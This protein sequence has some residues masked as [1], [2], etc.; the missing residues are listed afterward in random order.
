VPKLDR[1][2]RSV[3]DARGIG[4]DLAARGI[5]LSLGGQVYDP[6]DPMGKIF[7]NIL[8]TFAEFEVDLLRMRTREGMAVARAKGRLRGRQP[9][10]SA[11]QQAGPGTVIFGGGLFWPSRL[12]VYGTYLHTILGPTLVVG[13][14]WGLLFAPLTVVA[15]DKVPHTASGGAASLRNTAQQAGGSIGLAVLAAVAFTAAASS[16]RA[17]VA[18][19]VTAARAG[20]TGWEARPSHAAATGFSRG[21]DV[22]AGIMLLALIITAATIRIREADLV[23][24]N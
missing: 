22:A 18:R 2:A 3:P 19:A 20:H 21:F 10:L 1:L 23:G 11:K 16:G 15:M 5:R 14:G 9:K 8:A 13:P 12:S 7:F 4:D 24:P 6:A 17:A